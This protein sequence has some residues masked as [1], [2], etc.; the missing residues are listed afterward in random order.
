MLDDIEAVVAR[1]G[2]P[3]AVKRFATGVAHRKGDREFEVVLQR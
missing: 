1:A 3:L 2:T